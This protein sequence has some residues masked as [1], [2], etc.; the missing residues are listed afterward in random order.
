M[1]TMKIAL[2]TLAVLATGMGYRLVAIGQTAGTPML[3]LSWT[4]PVDGGPVEYYTLERALNPAPPDTTWVEA[5]RG[6][7][8]TATLPWIVG[9]VVYRARAWNHLGEV[10]GGVVVP[11]GDP[12]SGPAG[13]RSNTFIDDGVPAQPGKVTGTVVVQ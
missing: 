3:A 7:A 12:R 13:P 4:A 5:W 2:L 6:T 10:V 11:V 8:R 9:A 1:K